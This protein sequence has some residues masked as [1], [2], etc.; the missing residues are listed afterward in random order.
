[1]SGEDWQVGD[2]AICIGTGAWMNGFGEPAIG[3]P[4]GS[5]HLVVGVRIFSVTWQPKWKFWVKPQTRIGLYLCGKSSAFE[6]RAFRK[7][8]PHQADE[9]DAETIRLLNGQPVRED[10]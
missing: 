3:L 2:I 9:E 8:R 10:A 4:F 5:R 1:M 7:A 6:S